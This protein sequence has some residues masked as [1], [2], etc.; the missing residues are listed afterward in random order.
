MTPP[1]IVFSDG[2]SL[3]PKIGSQTQ[4]IPP[5]TSVKDNKVRSAAGNSFDPIEYNINPQH[6]KKPCSADNDEFLN[7][8]K[9]FASEKVNTKDEKIA[10][11]KPAIATVVNF[12][13]SFLHLNETE[14][15]ENPNAD[16]SPTSNPN[17]VPILL[18]FDAIK[19]IP[20]AAIIIAVNVVIEIF[21]LRKT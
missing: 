2:I 6:T 3:I 4:N 17:N 21:S 1:I 9:K 8:V 18:L 7:V 14:K 5:I 11:N 20:I 10:Q 19:K 15:I 12:G 16:I 13:V